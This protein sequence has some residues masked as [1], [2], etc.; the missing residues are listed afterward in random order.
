LGLAGHEQISVVFCGLNNLPERYNAQTEF[1]QSRTHPGGNITGIY[2]K[3]YVNKSLQVIKQIL[4]QCKKV[5][6]ITDYSPTGEA[7][8]RQFALVA[9]TQ[10]LPVAWEVR[11]VATF[12]DYK[13]LIFELNADP[14]VQAIYPTALVLTQGHTGRV[15]YREILT[16]TIQHATLPEIPLSYA[17]SK[18]GLFGGAAVNV[19]SMGFAAGIYAIDILEGKNP[20]DLPIV[21][22]PEYALI[23]N[24]A[25]ADSLGI[26]IPPSVLMACDAVY[27]SFNISNKP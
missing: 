12:E 8:N 24:T 15:T 23:F 13:K 6:G 16:W 10:K 11:R 5:V 25:R 14:E 3:L 2:E 17:F 21:D 4:P 20:G 27:T 9:R 18:I 1:M 26:T 22:A 19:E 7:I